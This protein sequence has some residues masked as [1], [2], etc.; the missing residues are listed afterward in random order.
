MP[1]ARKLSRCGLCFS[2]V[3][4]LAPVAKGFRIE[5]LSHNFYDL[6]LA[7]AELNFDGCKGRAV[8]PRHLDDSMYT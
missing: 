1:V 7:K 2:S 5:V 8:L 4:S 6:G 3:D